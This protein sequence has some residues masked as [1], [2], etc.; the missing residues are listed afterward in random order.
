[1]EDTKGEEEVE[2]EEETPVVTRDSIK[3]IKENPRSTIPRKLVDCPELGG[4]A[5][6]FGLSGGERMKVDAYAGGGPSTPG[7]SSEK[8]MEG[9]AAVALRES[10]ADDALQ[11]FTVP[12]PDAGKLLDLGYAFLVRI[13]NESYA[14]DFGEGAVQAIMKAMSDLGKAEE[15]P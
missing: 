7:H 2:A 11:L 4:K 8:F 6:V 15:T 3:A 13:Q 9:Y 5:W 10:D 14:L 12:G 1:M